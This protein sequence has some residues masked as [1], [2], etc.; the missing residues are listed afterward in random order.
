MKQERINKMV[1]SFVIIYMI[2]TTLKDKV[3]S[4]YE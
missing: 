4:W 3:I 2:M 1:K